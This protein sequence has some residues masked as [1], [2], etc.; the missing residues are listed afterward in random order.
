MIIKKNSP[1][2][3]RTDYFFSVKIANYREVKQEKCYLTINK[4]KNEFKNFRR[5]KR[6]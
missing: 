3:D 5:I 6:K 2:R 1:L 4:S